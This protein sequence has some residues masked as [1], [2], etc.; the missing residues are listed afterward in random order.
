MSTIDFASP[1]TS[2][3]T[4]KKKQCAK[5]YSCGNTCIAKGAQCRDTASGQVKN[6]ADWMAK[7]AGGAIVKKAETAD[8]GGGKSKPR[9]KIDQIDQKYASANP[10]DAD[11]DGWL[12]E[13]LREQTSPEGLALVA[14]MTNHHA[15]PGGVA[16]NKVSERVKGIKDKESFIRA[17]IEEE[18]ATSKHGKYQE[19]RDVWASFSRYSREKRLK[20]MA[21]LEDPKTSNEEKS[22]LKQKLDKDRQDSE[23]AAAETRSNFDRVPAE[24]YKKLETEF[25]EAIAKHK[26]ESQDL[27]AKIAKGDARTIQAETERMLRPFDGYQDGDRDA[28]PI[29]TLKRHQEIAKRRLIAASYTP[30]EQVLGVNPGASSDEIK[31]AYRKAAFKSHPDRGG[32]AAA[33]RKVNE[34]YDKL[35]Q[36]VSF[37][38][39]LELSELQWDVCLALGALEFVEASQ[40]F[41]E[42]FMNLEF[43]DRQSKE[44][45][46]IR[47]GTHTSSN[48][49]TVSF[50][51]SDLEEIAA[52]YDPSHFQAPLI[53]SHDTKGMGDRQLAHSEFAYGAP[54]ALKVVGDRLRAV[55][56]KIS[57]EFVQWVRDGKLLSVS[58]SIYL[59]GSPT[60]PTP[61]KLSLRHIAGLGKSPP[62]IK[63]MSPLSLSELTFDEPEEGLVT[64]SESIVFQ[65]P[66]GEKVS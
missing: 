10:S 40:Q 11:A 12:K 37:S 30:P 33:F 31:S 63:G 1:K 27:Q 41:T 54:K 55:F 47:T 18:F 6:Y 5:G 32:S 57:P 48:G 53:I 61:G 7:Q 24:R 21:D 14:M 66:C 60:N 20:M 2:G 45:E 38:E 28:T 17:T 36:S 26:T 59:R 23:K 13:R 4:Q 62:A 22:K 19:P 46:I 56:E 44:I 51:R 25:D 50:N 15:A 49:I 64:L 52:T 42:Q 39:F 65:S 9:S 34:A 43:S 58:S 3:H 29:T 8:S 35:K 16:W